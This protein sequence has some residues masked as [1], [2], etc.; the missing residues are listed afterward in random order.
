MRACRRWRRTANAS[1]WSTCAARCRPTTVHWADEIHPSG[2]GFRRL[3]QDLLA[4]D[5]RRSFPA[6]DS[7][8]ARRS[9]C[10]R[11]SSDCSRHVAPRLKAA[12]SGA[13]R[14]LR[15]L[16]TGQSGKNQPAGRAAVRARA[17]G[18]PVP[19]RSA[20]ASSARYSG[21]TEKNLDAL[22]KAA[23]AS[24]AVLMF[25]DTDHLFG[26]APTVEDSGR[27]PTSRR[28]AAARSASNHTTAS[29]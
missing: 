26:S 29:W 2:T 23:E 28:R 17:V 3:A 13:R 6:G 16:F 5:P 10:G 25:D 15:V 14:G 21:D 8:D 19:D 4:A 27:F 20:A 9:T 12:Q 1:S 22:F 7:T 24:D 18:R 11:W